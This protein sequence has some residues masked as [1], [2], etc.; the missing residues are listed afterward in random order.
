MKTVRVEMMK[1]Q[2]KKEIEREK[3]KRLQKVVVVVCVCVWGGSAIFLITV[4]K[5]PEMSQ[6]RRRILR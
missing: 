2:K 1:I 6:S 4:R 5:Q 3:G